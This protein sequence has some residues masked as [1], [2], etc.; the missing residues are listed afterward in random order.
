MPV[1]GYDALRVRFGRVR[2]TLRDGSAAEIEAIG[3]TARVELDVPA[4]GRRP[5]LID[6]YVEDQSDHGPKLHVLKVRAVEAPG[7]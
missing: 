5:V 1:S 2:G 6:L 3:A 7:R 4:G